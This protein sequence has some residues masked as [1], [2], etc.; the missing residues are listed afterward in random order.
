MNCSVF[1]FYCSTVSVLLLPPSRVR[2][3][4]RLRQNKKNEEEWE[5][6][7]YEFLTTCLTKL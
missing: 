1:P 4:Y 5:D 2:Q 6:N 3:F 7:K